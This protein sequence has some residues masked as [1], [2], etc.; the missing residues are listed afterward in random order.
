MKKKGKM[1][2]IWRSGKGDGFDESHIV[3]LFYL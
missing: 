2:F 1:N 3:S